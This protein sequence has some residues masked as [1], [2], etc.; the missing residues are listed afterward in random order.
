[1]GSYQL[2]S[3]DGGSPSP[4]VDV[5]GSA[6]R[7]HDRRADNS[8][9]AVAEIPLDAQAPS[10]ARGIT[11]QCL[12]DLVARPVIENAQLLVTELVTNSLLHSGAPRGLSVLVRVSLWG[13]RCRLEV[14]DPGD[15]ATIAR[16]P[17]DR[18]RGDG[19]GLNLVEMLS[20][21]WGV[22]HARGGPTRVWA[23][24]PCTAAGA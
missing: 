11:A 16:R 24:L 20:E 1:V 21:S 6:V 10:V 12:L 3:I 17:P 19:V 4:L 5:S 14:E 8:Q 7:F 23:Q 9:L 22:I 13:N 18:V 15:G 2:D